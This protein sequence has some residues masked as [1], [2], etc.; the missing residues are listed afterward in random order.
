MSISKTH[1]KKRKM[2]QTYLAKHKHTKLYFWKRCPLAFS[3]DLWEELA[4]FMDIAVSDRIDLGHTFHK[5]RK[6]EATK[7]AGIL[8]ERKLRSHSHPRDGFMWIWMPI[9]C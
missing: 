1:I 4:P 2:Q 7:P 8:N 3:P 6:V 9:G 5:V